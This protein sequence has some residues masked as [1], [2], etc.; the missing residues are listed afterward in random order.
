MRPKA[1][2]LSQLAAYEVH[3]F[4]QSRIIDWHEYTVGG[5]TKRLP[6]FIVQDYKEFYM[7]EFD[8][9]L[10]HYASNDEV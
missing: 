10:I 7:G 9:K 4:G 6:E 3:L 1:H 2:L 8:P 5:I